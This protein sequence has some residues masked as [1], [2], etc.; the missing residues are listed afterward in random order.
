MIDKATG[1]RRALIQPCL[2]KIENKVP[3]LSVDIDEA[4]SLADRTEICTE[5]SHS[6]VLH[7]CS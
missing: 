6:A 3:Y 2:T 4:L 1:N 7:V 5:S